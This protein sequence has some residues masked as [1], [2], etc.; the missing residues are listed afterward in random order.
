[1]RPAVR[2]NSV[3]GWLTAVTAALASGSALATDAPRPLPGEEY[4]AAA[5]GGPVHSPAPAP[6]RKPGEGAGPF[7]RLV[8]RGATLID[9]TG[10]PPIGPVDIVVVQDRI[11]QIQSVG[12]PKMPIREKNR[13]PKGDYEVDATGM[14]VLPGFINAHA[15]I[16]DANQGRVGDVPP[17][18][19]VYKLWLGHG[20]T[21]VR[22]A[23]SFNGL[24]WTL[25]E[26]RRSAAHE[27]VAPRIAAYAGFPVEVDTPGGVRTPEEA[28]RWVDA[29]AVAGADGIKFLGS[30]PDIM[31]AAL[32]EAKIKNLRSACHHSQ[33]AVARMNALDT[34][35]WGLTSLEHWYGLPEALFIDRRVQDYPADYNY[36][37][38][39]DRFG[40]AGRLWAQAAPRGSERWKEVIATLKSRDFTLVPTF[41]IYEATRDA[42]R[43]RRAEW[44]DEYTL[45]TLLRWYEPNRES[46]GAFW[47][48][49]TTADEIAWKKNY[50]IWMSFVNDYKNAGGRVAV[51]DDAGYIYKLFGFAWVRELELLQEAGFL[52]LEAVRAA[53]L[54]GAELLGMAGRLG[55]VEVGKNADLVVVAENPLANFKVLYGTGALHLD[56]ATHKPTR[57]GGVRYTIHDG[58]VYDAPALLADVRR[59]VADAKTHELA[60]K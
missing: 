43:E 55:S 47:F 13:P 5:A 41:T 50:A 32:A 34:S 36:N 42:M 24:K 56:D 30:P 7:P 54:S 44:H 17:A 31:Q 21:T 8:I 25:N 23:G 14:Y 58:I 35:G 33:T 22:E 45:P 39:Y 52:P 15:H 28:R 12:F 3:R 59:M 6:N 57:V 48:S 60:G 40:Q 2:R 11:V 20:I 16:A 10:S 1:M 26:R 9:G 4:I 37:D 46:H 38:E 49:W 51:G 18:E 27:T 19:Y 29:I 53:T